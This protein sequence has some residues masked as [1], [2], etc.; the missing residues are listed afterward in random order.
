MVANKK[1]G[2]GLLSHPDLIRKVLDAA[3]AQN[4]IRISVKMRL[5]RTNPDEIMT[6]MPML[7]EYPLSR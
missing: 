2:S 4:D 5:G 7:N 6:L 3:C 1:R